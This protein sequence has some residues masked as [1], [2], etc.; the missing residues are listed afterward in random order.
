VGGSSDTDTNEQ[1]SGHARMLALLQEVIERAP[2]EHFYLD[3]KKARALR[4]RLGALR[5]EAPDLIKWELYLKLG[6]EE[7]RLGR[8]Q[9]AIE[10]LT[11]AYRLLPNIEHELAPGWAVRLRF[12]LGMAYLRLGETQNCCLRNVPDSCLLPIRSGGIHVQQEASKEAIKYFTEVLETA[13][14][15]TEPYLSGVWLLNIAYMTIGG[16]PDGVP[17]AYLIPPEEFE[18]EESFPRFP[19]VA[20]RAG[21][22]TFSLSGGTVA[23]DFDQDGYLDLLVSTYDPTGQVRL[24]I[25]T[26][27][28]TFSDYTSQAGLTGILGGLNMVQAD[29]DNDG[30]ADILMLR[31]AWLGKAG[32]HPN[33]LLR[34]NGDGTFTDVTFEAGLGEVHYPTQTASWADYDNDGDVDLYVGNETNDGLK[35]P[36]QLFLNQGDGTFTDVAP[37]AGA[38]NDRFTKAVIW[39]D[40]DGDRLPDL[41]VSNLGEANRLYHNNG[42]GTFE[43]VA[44]SLGVTGPKTSF[45]AWFWDFDNDGVLDIFAS[46]YEAIV[47]HIAAVHLGMG[48]DGE[49]AHLF[50]GD[51]RGGFLE[52]ARER[53]LT[54][55]NA[56]MGSN[57]GDLDND[58][59][60]DFY[61]GTGYP[62]YFA[63][64]PNVMY[65]NRDGKRFVDVS[66]AGGFGHLQK[67]HAVV[68]ADL[69]ND[70]D[71]DVFEQMGGALA[72]DKF[73]DVLYEN[74]GFGN[75]WISAELFGVQSNRSAIGARIHVVVREDGRSRSIYKHVNSGGTFGANPLRQTIGLGKAEKIELLELF[76]PTSNRTQTFQDVP[77]DRFVQIRETAGRL[78]VLPLP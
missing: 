53:N 70:G 77:L 1:T 14:E 25:N 3:D 9:Q 57:F 48:Y 66:M 21:V 10:Y 58:G 32:R 72:G 18:S 5:R 35:G 62:P 52:V 39:G 45:P 31:G 29:F 78:F 59:Y 7:Q 54:Q 55:P 50:R 73:S 42:D 60:L 47:M 38:T 23:E 64:M 20:Q 34:N 27:E 37:S 12:R 33:S 2:D 69:D 46:A 67:G 22:D 30:D 68:F 49:L 13:D 24:F 41:Y 19:N 51:G 76:W 44:P 40:Y 8:E 28:G 43:D 16:S 61:L 63:L 74:P 15:G 17:P 6:E 56:P 36:C 26:E 11:R 71:Q 75:H 4:A 65:R